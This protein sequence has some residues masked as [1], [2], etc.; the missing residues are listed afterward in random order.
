[1]SEN[2]TI[3]ILKEAILLEHKGKALY[4]SVANQSENREAKELFEM[5]VTEEE[6]HVEIL[7]KQ[8]KLVAE[9]KDFDA[10]G[11]DDI[12]PTT[13]DAVLSGKVINGIN[14]AG[15]EAA[16]VSAALEFEKN[17]VA[18]YGKQE[19][20]AKSDDEKKLFNWLVKWEKEHM[21]MLA[22][23]DNEIKESVWYDN[24]FWPLD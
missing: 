14:A 19:A 23:I 9:G 24:N 3:D 12:A 8:L 17:A 13:V 21:T 18:Y 1:M 10:S 4:K 11:L 15:Y 5:L 22:K 16:V 2:K 7:M 6:K 20:D